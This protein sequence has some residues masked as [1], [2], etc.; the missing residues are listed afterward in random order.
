MR[1]L[2]LNI[3]PVDE[4]N[5]EIPDVVHDEAYG[6]EEPKDTKDI[7]LD[8]FFAESEE[9]TAPVFDESSLFE[10]DEDGLFD[11]NMFDNFDDNN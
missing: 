9:Q 5:Q 3:Y 2:C 8:N 10:D 1:S 6:D 11:Q 7:E 4:N